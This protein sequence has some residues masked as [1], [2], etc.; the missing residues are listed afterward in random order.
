MGKLWVAG[1]LVWPGRSARLLMEPLLVELLL[2]VRWRLRVPGSDV[3]LL[4]RRP[5]IRDRRW[6][7]I[8][9]TAEITV[10][11]LGHGDT[12]MKPLVSRRVRKV[13]RRSHIGELG[14]TRILMTRSLRLARIDIDLLVRRHGDAGRVRHRHL[15]RLPTL[16]KCQKRIR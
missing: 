12:L 9:R 15:L 10:A 8:H 7:H 6:W 3:L 11:R 16:K 14:L 4:R 1:P 13:R 5:D 2:G